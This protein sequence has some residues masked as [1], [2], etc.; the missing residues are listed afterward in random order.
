[1]QASAGEANAGGA[2]AGEANA[3]GAN[4]GE[5]NAGEASSPLRQGISRGIMPG[6]AWAGLAFLLSFVVIRYIR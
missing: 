4:A 1:M 6:L 5:A 3:G 2:N